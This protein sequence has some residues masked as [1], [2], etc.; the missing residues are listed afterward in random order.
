MGGEHQEGAWSR[1]L[2]LQPGP[3]SHPLRLPTLVNSSERHHLH[4]ITDVRLIQYRRQVK[5]VAHR[6]ASQRHDDVACVGWGGRVSGAEA[7]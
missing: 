4:F 7:L 5:Q 2:S 1:C 6:P 3:H